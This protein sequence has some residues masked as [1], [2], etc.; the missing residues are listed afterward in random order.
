[1]PIC[2]HMPR[3]AILG[4]VKTVNSERSDVNIPRRRAS[5]SNNNR[6]RK[7][8]SKHWEIVLNGAIS[9]RY[10][11]KHRKYLFDSGEIL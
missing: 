11:L 2:K 10:G 6:S 7:I 5:T 9:G 3:M 1:M 8:N 4:L